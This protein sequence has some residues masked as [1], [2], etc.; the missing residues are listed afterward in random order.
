M[1]RGFIAAL[2]GKYRAS[3]GPAL[4]HR[5]PNSQRKFTLMPV[6]DTTSSTAICRAVF[7]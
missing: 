1:Y 7:K 5:T 4:A 3:A 6:F 2:S